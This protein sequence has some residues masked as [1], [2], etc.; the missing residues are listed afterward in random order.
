MEREVTPRAASLGAFIERAVEQLQRGARGQPETD[1]LLFLGN[2][3]DSIPRL[4]IRDPILKPTEV[5]LWSVIRTLVEPAGPAAMP[6]Y[7][8][9]AAYCNVASRA[10]VSNAIA[11]LR[12][13]RWLSLCARVRDD[14]GRYAGNVYALHDEPITLG[15][16][17]HLD[18]GY[19]SFLRDMAG[20][21]DR[22]VRRVAQ[23][24][25]DT[26]EEGIE[27]GQDVT[28][29]TGLHI[30]ACQHLTFLGGLT[31]AAD[32]AVDTPL[33]ISQ[34]RRRALRENRVQKK[35]N[36]AHQVQKLNSGIETK[37]KQQLGNRVQKLNSVSC[38]SSDQK[39][40]TTKD[41]RRDFEHRSRSLIWPSRL[42]PAECALVSGYL[43]KLDDALA[44]DVLDELQ[45]RLRDTNANPVRN[46]VAWLI[47]SSKRAAQGEFQL[48]SLGLGVRRSR[49]A[50]AVLAA[51][52][53]AARAS[54]PVAA[55]PTQVAHSALAQRVEAM[56]T[57]RGGRVAGGEQ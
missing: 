42:S 49:A 5:R 48:T 20:H 34:P 56:R 54:P 46:P 24:V 32:M 45:G 44:Q 50:Q 29:D 4:L 7:D 23:A 55:D 47:A 33:A 53:E 57:R 41:S 25:L 31:D 22:R 3:N 18:S 51:Q 28:R 37:E 36:S 40:T 26:I 1:G 9:L 38:S 8:T 2:W 19:V 39:T 6:D 10:T 52:D 15:D 14:G 17:M 27:A 21:R 43:S 12:I 13:T 30:R 35:L 16:A 11:V